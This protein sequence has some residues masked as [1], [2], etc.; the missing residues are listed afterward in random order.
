MPFEWRNIM[1]NPT[2]KLL[3]E[4]WSEL[5]QRLMTEDQFL[6]KARELASNEEVLAFIREQREMTDRLLGMH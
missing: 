6:V 4:L 1:D 3:V 5:K 2:H